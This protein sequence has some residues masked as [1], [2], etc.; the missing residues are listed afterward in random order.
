VYSNFYYTITYINPCG[1]DISSYPTEFTVDNLVT[2]LEPPPDTSSY[3]FKEFIY[4]TYE[5]PG[6]VTITLVGEAIQNVTYT[7]TNT[8]VQPASYTGSD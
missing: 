8:Y 1:F 7:Y 4:P 6:D 3:K 5:L 2:S